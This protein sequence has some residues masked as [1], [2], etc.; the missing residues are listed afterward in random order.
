MKKLIFFLLF[1]CSGFASAQWTE[2]TSG[3]TTL[4]Y[5]VSSVDDDGVWACGD[6]G[7][8]LRTVN[9][10]IL[11]ST[12]TSPNSAISFYTIQGIDALTAVVGGSDASAA[13]VYKTVDG[14]ATWTLTFSQPG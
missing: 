6:G 9:S 14:G 5:S 10:G 4:I 3:I 8:V 11:W 2:Q 1:I 13:Y 12:V 7:K